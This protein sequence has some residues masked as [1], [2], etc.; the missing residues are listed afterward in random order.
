VFERPLDELLDLSREVIACLV[1][2]QQRT[3]ESKEETKIDKDD[4]R[5]WWCVKPRWGGGTGGPIGKEESREP[6]GVSDEPLSLDGSVGENVSGLLGGPEVGGMGS[7][8]ALEARRGLGG[9]PGKRRTTTAGGRKTM[10][11][12]DNY[13][14]VRPPSSTWDRKARYQAIGRER[15]KEWD[16]VFVVS[17][18]NHHVS[19]ARFRV[20]LQLVRVLDGDEEELRVVDGQRQGLVMWKSRWYDM[21]L[22]EDR[23]E[24]M[25][26][27]W[28]MM[29][30]LMRK[31]DEHKVDARG[32]SQMVDA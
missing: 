16:D 17:A 10:S 28:G 29:G 3:R 21:F 5:N 13:R 8:P 12:Y 30:W 18:M 11:I 27:I 32:D 22:V 4:P 9:V 26:S 2:A 15:G 23:I 1:T 31:V 6:A 14:M 19:V 24:A 7:S 25:C 20:P